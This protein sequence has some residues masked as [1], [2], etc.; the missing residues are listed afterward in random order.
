MAFTPDEKFLVIGG[1][2]ICY[3][4]VETKKVEKK[5]TGHSDEV[6]WVSR[7]ACNNFM[8][9]TSE[10]E[11]LIWDAKTMEKEISIEEKIII[12]FSKNKTVAGFLHDGLFKGWSDDFLE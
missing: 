6:I 9:T 12:C 8:L 11:T 3:F 2:R 1:A 10:M 4:N 5:L 7:S